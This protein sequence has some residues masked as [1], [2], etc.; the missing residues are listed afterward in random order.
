MGNSI[1]LIP[2]LSYS[3]VYAC[4]MVIKNGGGGGM[5]VAKGCGQRS[6]TVS[7]LQLANVRVSK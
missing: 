7:E 2:C 4:N 5:L 3:Y 1:N 6:D